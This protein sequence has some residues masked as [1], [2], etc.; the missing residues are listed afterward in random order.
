MVAA[1]TGLFV[2]KQPGG[3]FTINDERDTTGN[4][5]F[6]DSGASNGGDTVGHGDNP[7]RPFL[8]IDFAIGQCTANNGDVIYVMPGHAETIAAASGIDVDVAGITIVGLGVDEDRPTITMSAVG[9]TFELAAAGCVIKNLLFKVTADTT[10]VIDINAAGCKV[11]ACEIR[12]GTAKEFVTA[13]DV[14]GGGANNCDRTII[15]SCVITSTAAAGS[16]NGIELGE[17]A[18]RVQ[19][20][21]CT[22]LGDFT[23]ACI[24]N[25]TGKV[26]TNLMVLDSVLENTQTGDHAIELVSACTGILGRNLYKTDITQATASDPG[27]C[28]SFENYHCDVIDVSGIISPLIT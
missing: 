16:T 9:S 27:S 3:V 5:F 24:H 25:P 22:I 11:L 21:N 15:D 12:H 14:N 4:I 18:D 1:R 20:R 10:V 6:V 26:L 19:I 23:N 17:V 13:I 8:T 7:D 2:R 28:F